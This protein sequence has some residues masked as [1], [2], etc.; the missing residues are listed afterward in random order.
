MELS[1]GRD[2]PD[3]SLVQD[4]SGGDAVGGTGREDAPLLQPNS[5]EGLQS[6]FEPA[7]PILQSEKE[8]L[9][10]PF[11]LGQGIAALKGL[12]A[13]VAMLLAVEAVLHLI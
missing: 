2:L 4:G 12:T 13:L 11:S 3:A 9:L 6:V 5:Q 1:D 7:P 8:P 10:G